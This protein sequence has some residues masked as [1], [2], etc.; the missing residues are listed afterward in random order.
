MKTSGK[1]IGIM[2]FDSLGLD[3]FSEADVAALTTLTDQMTIATENAR[4]YAEAE[5]E[6]RRSAAILQSTRDAVMLIG[7][8]QRVQLM[9]PAAERV[10]SITAG[11][12][13]GQPL[14]Q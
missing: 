9:N 12:N 14:D 2:A 8:D 5:R 6:R 1:V 11:Q 13:I 7:P 4:L 10:L 3:A